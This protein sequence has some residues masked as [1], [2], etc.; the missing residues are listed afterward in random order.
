MQKIW[1]VNVKYTKT[2]TVTVMA[3]DPNQASRFAK[4]KFFKRFPEC[5]EADTTFYRAYPDE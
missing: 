4:E 2:E 3:E 5:S 1:Y